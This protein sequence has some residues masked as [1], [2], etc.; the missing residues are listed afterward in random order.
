M[1]AFRLWSFQAN[2]NF[3][4]FEIDGLNMTWQ[5]F[6]CFLYLIHT[7]IGILELA[8]PFVHD[9]YFTESLIIIAAALSIK[10]PPLLYAKLLSVRVTFC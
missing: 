9:T 6:V 3:L 10:I 8:T 1:S 7:G 5:V 4:S 2:S